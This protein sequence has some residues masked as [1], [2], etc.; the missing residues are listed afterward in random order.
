MP[1]PRPSRCLLLGIAAFA[2]TS[3]VYS[4]PQP[5]NAKIDYRTPARLIGTAR[6]DGCHRSPSELYLKERRTD[7][8]RLDESSIWLTQDLHRRAT[9]ALDESREGSLAERMAKILGD[10][11][12][13]R[14][15]CL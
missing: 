9:E 10:K 15:E 8:V 4:V 13:Q 5:P 1:L 6:C 14:V 12:N 7:I 2:A 11:L 3:A